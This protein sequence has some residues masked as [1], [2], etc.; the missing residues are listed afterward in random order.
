MVPTNVI[1]IVRSGGEHYLYARVER[2]YGSALAPCAKAY[3]R[4]S[5]VVVIAI[6]AVV[7][8]DAGCTSAF[9]M[10]A[11]S[12]SCFYVLQVGGGVVV[13]LRALDAVVVN[14]SA[15]CRWGRVSGNGRHV[16]HGLELAWGL[17]GAGTSHQTKGP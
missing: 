9:C 13:L 15:F 16:T 11:S 3:G 17:R 6:Q 5:K 8:F 14:V 10:Q 12:M 2:R 1:V 4:L 7:A